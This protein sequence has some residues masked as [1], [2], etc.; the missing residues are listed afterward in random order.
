MNKYLSKFKLFD[1][2]ELR[3]VAAL[4]ITKFKNRVQSGKDATGKQFKPYSEGYAKYKAHNMRRF[5]DNA[6]LQAYSGVSISSNNVANPDFTLTGNTM[7]G[8]AVKNVKS[9]KYTIG[10]DGER[11]DIVDGNMRKG[12][13]IASNIPESEY[14]WILSQ[15][16]IA[17]DKEAKKIKNVKVHIRI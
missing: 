1:I 12:R 5:T 16:G 14:N 2:N 10:W 13:D 17:F 8:L 15:L 7:R 6:R 4:H 9:D 3:K 11:A